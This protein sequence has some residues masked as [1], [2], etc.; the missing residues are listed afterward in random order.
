MQR[1]AAS[2][3]G[4]LVAFSVLLLSGGVSVVWDG[5]RILGS[6]VA[7]LPGFYLD[8]RGGLPEGEV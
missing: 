7:A 2:S 4:D 8:A 6:G 3:R 5:A 1:G